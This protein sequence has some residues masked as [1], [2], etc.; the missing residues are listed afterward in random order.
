[1]SKGHMSQEKNKYGGWAVEGCGKRRPFP[2][3]GIVG[4]DE[5]E[6]A[7][8]ISP[9]DSEIRMGQ[10]ARGNFFLTQGR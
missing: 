6:I 7:T 1:M 10:S 9:K 4:A 2:I 5:V 8:L 3:L